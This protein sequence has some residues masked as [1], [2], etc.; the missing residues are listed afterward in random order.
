MA[1]RD[2]SLIQDYS[3]DIDKQSQ[4]WSHWLPLSLTFTAFLLLCITSAPTVLTRTNIAS[5]LL[6]LDQHQ[7]RN[8]TTRIDLTG[9]GQLR[10]VHCIRSTVAGTKGETNKNGPRA[11]VREI[12]ETASV[13]H[14]RISDE[15]SRKRGGVKKNKK[16]RSQPICIC[17]PSAAC[18]KGETTRNGPKAEACEA[19]KTSPERH[20]RI[21]GEWSRKRG[22][23]SKN[24]KS[25]LN[26]PA[27]EGSW[28]SGVRHRITELNYPHAR[29]P[30]AAAT[31]GDIQIEDHTE[32]PR[33][34]YTELPKKK[35]DYT[36][37]QRGNSEE[38]DRVS[39]AIN[40]HRREVRKQGS[41][42]RTRTARVAAKT[43]KR[44]SRVDKN[45][46]IATAV[47]G[48]RTEKKEDRTAQ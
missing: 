39:V 27:N 19:G 7:D 48:R 20:Q 3:L 4:R 11:E 9:H 25:D 35:I 6:D 31:P 30:V 16:I 22:G 45:R 42:R 36:L 5:I 21:S 1:L 41:L 2:T 40:K 15:G 44:G 46:R 43:A 32:V 29:D 18:T 23:V 17:R 8:N 47:Q 14:R 10:S 34:L 26:Q 33:K 13:R 28:L 37:Q 24:K 38:E 12:G